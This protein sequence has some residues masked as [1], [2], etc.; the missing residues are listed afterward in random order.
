MAKKL[1]LKATLVSEASGVGQEKI[2]NE[3]CKEFSN[4]LII[5]PWCQRIVE[6]KV[7]N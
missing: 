5:I 6:I 1:L 3:I 2:E 7:V 4:G